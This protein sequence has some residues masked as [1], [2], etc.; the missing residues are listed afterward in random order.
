MT[1]RQYQDCI[2]LRGG[3]GGVAAKPVVMPY[4]EGR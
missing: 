2:L 1:F 3:T 4:L